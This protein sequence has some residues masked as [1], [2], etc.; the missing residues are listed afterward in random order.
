[1]FCLLLILWLG[2]RK[3]IWLFKNRFS[4]DF[5][6]GTRPHLDLFRG[7]KLVKNKN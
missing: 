7:S 6:L 5:A 1:M 3:G 4:K 2:D